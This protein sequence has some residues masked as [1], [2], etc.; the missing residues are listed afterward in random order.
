MILMTYEKDS[1]CHIC[2][3]DIWRVQKHIKAV[4]VICGYFGQSCNSS[5]QHQT[6][7]THIKFEDVMLVLEL[8]GDL[9]LWGMEVAAPA[10]S[11]MS[12]PLST[13]VVLDKGADLRIH[14]FY[15]RHKVGNR[16]LQ[17]GSL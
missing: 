13:L 5:R 11:F 15:Q 16:L 7:S 2:Q 14:H 10:A 3:T 12:P 1:T 9:K 6:R 8:G 17:S 4:G